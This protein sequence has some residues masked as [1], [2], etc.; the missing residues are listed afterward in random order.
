MGSFW[1]FFPFFLA[2]FSQFLTSQNKMK[3]LYHKLIPFSNNKISSENFWFFLGAGGIS[4]QFNTFLV[5]GA[6]FCLF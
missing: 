4:S 5:L 6:I 3:I 1:F 2:R